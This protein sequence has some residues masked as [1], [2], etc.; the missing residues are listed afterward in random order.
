MLKLLLVEDQKL[1][2]E[3][4]SALLSLEADIEIL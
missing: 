2:R 3:G 4:L 1:I